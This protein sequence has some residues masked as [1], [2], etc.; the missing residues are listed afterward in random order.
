M[1]FNTLDKCKEH[2]AQVFFLKQ[3]TKLNIFS[4]S[5][6]NINFLIIFSI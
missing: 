6:K 4:Q 5:F 2:S 3:A 1:T